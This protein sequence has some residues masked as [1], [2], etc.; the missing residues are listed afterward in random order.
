MRP[1]ACTMIACILLCSF[2]CVRKQK[3]EEAV[4]HEVTQ[5]KGHYAGQPLDLVVTRDSTTKTEG[6]IITT[7]PIP[8]PPGG[9]G[10]LATAIGSGGAG[11]L[12][13]GAVAWYMNRKK[14]K[15]IEKRNAEY[16]PLDPL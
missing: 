8:S 9:F 14:K 12:A 5:I 13:L 6:T 10:G 3:K 11:T 7:I 15:I 1:L 2:Q 16:V 4:T